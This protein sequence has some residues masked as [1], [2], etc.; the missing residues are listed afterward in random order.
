MN[1]DVY[2]YLQIQKNTLKRLESLMK[3][4][5]QNINK[6]NSLIKMFKK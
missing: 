4:S 1:N 6:T 3:T 2:E 5:N